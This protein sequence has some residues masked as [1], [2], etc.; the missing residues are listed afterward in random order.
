MSCSAVDEGRKGFLNS[1][2]QLNIKSNGSGNERRA[3]PFDEE[4]RGNLMSNFVMN[5][6]RL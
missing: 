5:P 1:R 3:R 4:A 6:A 2:G